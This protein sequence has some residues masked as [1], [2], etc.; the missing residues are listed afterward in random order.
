[1]TRLRGR[2]PRGER[3]HDH[4]PAGSWSTTTLVAAVRGDGPCAPFLL[5]GAL[6]TDA[7][8]VYVEKVLVPALT[9][10][11][12]VVMDNLSVHKTSAIRPLIEGAGASLLYL[13]PYSPD[14]NPVEKM[15]SKMKAHLRAAKA[16]TA[17]ALT[18][19]VSQALDAITT[20]DIKGWFESCGYKI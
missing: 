1:M 16:R 19:A 9:P 2:A 17:D 13:P 4:A 3:L 11:D 5:E 12:I 14:Y 10:G 18:Q 6:D 7:F 20:T 15:W 8:T